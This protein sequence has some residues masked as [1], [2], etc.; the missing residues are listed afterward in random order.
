MTSHLIVNILWSNTKWPA[1]VTG[2]RTI[3]WEPVNIM[4]SWIEE[5]GTGREKTAHMDETRSQSYSHR[6]GDQVSHRR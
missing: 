3:V 2:P 6:V 1:D 5:S 4:K